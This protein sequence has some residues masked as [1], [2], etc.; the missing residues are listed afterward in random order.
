MT[1]S[2]LSMMFFLSVECRSESFGWTR[3]GSLGGVVAVRFEDGEVRSEETV[4]SALG[5]QRGFDPTVDDPLADRGR[6]H[7]ATAG[8]FTG[9]DVWASLWHTSIMSYPRFS[10]QARIAG[11][12]PNDEKRPDTPGHWML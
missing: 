2:V 7:T 8:D 1:I 9:C 10:R 5:D 3:S 4:V 12:L 11:V 6:V